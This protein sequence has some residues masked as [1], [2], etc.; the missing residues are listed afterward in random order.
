MAGQQRAL[1]P[2]PGGPQESTG[3]EGSSL[4]SLVELSLI[5]PTLMFIP[6]TYRYFSKAKVV[7][8]RVCY[9][10]RDHPCK[11]LWTSQDVSV[12]LGGLWSSLPL[13]NA[14]Y[15]IL[16]SPSAPSSGKARVKFGA[17]SHGSVFFCFF[18]LFKNWSIR[19]MATH[20]RILAWRVPW[21]RGAWR[22]T[23]H[24]VAKSPDRT[25]RLTLCL[26]NCLTTLC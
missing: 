3:L 2:P 25:E 22:A 15:L 12:S 11:V 24:G 21:T 19:G 1:L 4:S 5:D 18:S 14:D 17:W 13:G 10:D 6:W 23:V 20:S 7:I 26:H 8:T 9:E 16:P